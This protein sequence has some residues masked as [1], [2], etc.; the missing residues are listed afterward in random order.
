MRG[1]AA[2]APV[3]LT[4]RS[5]AL[6]AQSVVSVKYVGTLNKPK[7]IPGA[8][9][10]AQIAVP[11]FGGGSLPAVGDICVTAEVSAK[12]SPTVQRNGEVIIKQTNAGATKLEYYCV[13]GRRNEYSEGQPVA[14]LSSGSCSSCTG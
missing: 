5:G 1:A 7:D 4:L 12:V 8:G 10:M 3:V 2:I 9:Q 13:S 11:E 14:I 6:A